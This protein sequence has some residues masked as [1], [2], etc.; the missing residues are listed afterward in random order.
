MQALGVTVETDQLRSSFGV[1]VE[2]ETA[3]CNPQTLLC[4]V[5]GPSVA[6]V[7]IQGAPDS[8]YDVPAGQ[9]AVVGPL[10]GSASCKMSPA[11]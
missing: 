2:N 4:E 11:G 9:R 5:D 8:F 10:Y 7:L 6:R 3:T 1:G